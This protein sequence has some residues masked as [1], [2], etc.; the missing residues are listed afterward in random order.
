MAIWTESMRD[1]SILSMEKPLEQ[2]QRIDVVFYDSLGR[3]LKAM[4]LIGL[5]V[6]S[7]AMETIH[8]YARAQLIRDFAAFKC[9]AIHSFV[10]RT[11]SKR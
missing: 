7:Q 8:R 3:P 5:E 6:I 2:I 11:K 1:R 4:C 10:P 9:S